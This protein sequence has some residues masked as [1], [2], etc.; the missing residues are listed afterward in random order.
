MPWRD[1]VR[2]V[3]I[4]GGGPAGLYCGLL[5]KKANPALDITIVE[6]N[7]AGATY[8]WGVV[9]S[10]R[11][12]AEFREADYPTYREITDRFVVWDA[13]DILYGGERRRCGGHVIAGIARR[14]LLDILQQACDARGVR[15]RFQTEIAGPADWEGVADLVIAADG[16]NSVIRRAYAR[17]FQPSLREGK[18][19]YIWLGTRRVLGAFTFIFRETPFGLFQVHAYP[20]DGATST[21]IV[22]CAEETWRR[23]G[24]DVA[25]EA[26]SLAF[27]ES[28]FAEELGGQRLM[29]NNSKWINFATVKN[30]AWRH[31]NVVLLGDAAHTAHFSIGSGTKL[32][33]EDAI[34]LTRACEQYPD[35][36]Q[37]LAMYQMERKP[38][39]EAF[40]EAARASRTD[41]ENMRRY[42]GLP[43]GQ[44]ACHLLTRSGRISYDDLRLR[45]PLF[46][47]G[48]DRELAAAV[49]TGRAAG[50]AADRS[51]ASDATGPS[52]QRAAGEPAPPPS[53]LEVAPP[54]A[55]LPFVLRGLRLE[56]RIIRR[57]RPVFAARD[58]LIGGEEL[59]RLAAL[60]TSGAGVVMTA[61]VAVSADGR[62]T[63]GDPGMYRD[64]HAAAWAAVVRAVRG[65]ST[66]RIAITLNHAGRRGAAR[67]RAEGLDRPLRDG[68]PLL[69]PSPLP[70]AP[71]HPVPRA[72]GRTDMDRARDDFVRAA[73]QAHDAGVDA[74]HLHCGHGYLLG[75]FLSPLANRRTD[76]YGGRLQNRMRFPL[77]VLDA[78]RAAWADRPLTVAL[79]ATDWERRG[80]DVEEAAEMARVLKTHGCDAVEV[81]AGQTT[82]DSRPAYGRGFLT[83]YGD[84]IRNE[85]RVATMVGGHLT[86]T[87]EMHIL[88][89]AGRADLCITEPVLSEDVERATDPPFSLSLLRLRSH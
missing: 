37:A 14:A 81:L 17:V 20:Y 51:G 47:D 85:A 16:V 61:P 55:F 69:G 56:N 53:R 22:E 24:L 77:E 88:I 10:D 79:N 32:A 31:G 35:L 3:L 57:A 59:A 49:G 21:F 67:P 12:L 13:I 83:P 74:L 36:E 25:D 5:L 19:K 40:Q 68:W 65:R 2:R 50:G 63:P 7:P 60:A 44:F 75:S 38:A 8:G 82:P 4:A 73:R 80:I 86:R 34:A 46:V 9:F 33:M 11:T 64:D 84:V 52:G 27:C 70:Y 54:P 62:I 41:F 58:G 26:T 66:A 76:E 72:M 15:L 87:G 39:V 18:A 42:T 48:L 43:P 29:S 78:V 45:D 6:R 89:A 30:N 1:R 71:G 28:L 23:A